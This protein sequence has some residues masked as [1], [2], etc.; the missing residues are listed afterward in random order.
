MPAI[1]CESWRKAWSCRG[2]Q[3]ERALSM[4]PILFHL[5]SFSVSSFGLMMVLGFLS[6]GLLMRKDFVRK[7]VSS[8]LAWSIVLWGALGGIV[9]SR[10]LEAVHDWDALV[11]DPVGARRST[12]ARSPSRAETRSPRMSSTGKRTPRS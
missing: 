9:G 5:G 11:A 4:R 8:D 10:L 12:R 3:A 6:A 2:G 1:S 7:G